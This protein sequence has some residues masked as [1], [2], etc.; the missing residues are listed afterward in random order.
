MKSYETHTGLLLQIQEMDGV[1]LVTL[2][3]DR[4]KVLYSGKDQTS[5]KKVYAETGKHYEK[6]RAEEAQLG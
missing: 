6:R 1:Y 4:A 2:T 5:A 3:G